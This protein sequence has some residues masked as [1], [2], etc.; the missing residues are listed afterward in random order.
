MKI[1]RRVLDSVVIL[2]I[3]GDIRLGESAEVFSRELKSLLEEQAVLGVILNMENINYMDSTGLGELVG[4]LSR[5]KDEGKRLRLVKPN[6]V[7][8]K[9]LA[10]TRLDQFFKVCADEAS[11]LEDFVS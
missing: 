8:M 3:T 2:E 10:L 7:V 4:Y 5:F 11:A 6:P 1:V 9:L